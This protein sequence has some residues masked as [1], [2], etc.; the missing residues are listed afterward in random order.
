MKRLI[1]GDIHGCHQELMDLLDQAGLSGDDEIIA[2]G[3][4]IDRGPDSPAVVDFYRCA[5]GARSL[6]GNHER[7]HVRI[8]KGEIPASASQ[9]LARQQFSAIGYAE[10][11]AFFEGLPF[12][13]DLPEATLVHG[14]LDPGKSLSDQRPETL[15]G[16]LSG[17]SYLRRHYDAPWYELYAGEKPV[18][19]GHHDYSKVGKPMVINDRVFL[20]DTGC[21]YG[22]ALTGII[23]PDFQFLTVQSRRNYWGIAAAGPG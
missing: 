13:I 11:I 1:V 22:R 20:I 18:V 7:K 17:E 12:F 2:L 9:L 21:C 16:T 19:A 23:L 14:C 10:A 8:S 4:L 15:L 5:P 6:M 3:D